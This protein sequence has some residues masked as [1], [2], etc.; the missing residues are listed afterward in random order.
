MDANPETDRRTVLVVD[1]DEEVRAVTVAALENV[2]LEVIE[3]ESGREALQ[4]LDSP[5]PIDMVVTDVV[6]PGISGFRVARDAERRRPGI[7]VLVTSGYAGGLVDA[8]LPAERFLSKPF[9]LRELQLKVERLL[10]Q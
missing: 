9:R 5:Q 8:Q 2:G 3:A 6:M 4:V 7:K 1:D 10:H